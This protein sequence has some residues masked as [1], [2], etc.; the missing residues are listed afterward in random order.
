MSEA[1]ISASQ[2]RWYGSPGHFICGMHCRFH[3]CTKVG[4]FLVSTV[5]EYTP[6][7]MVA[8]GD[9]REG[10]WIAENYPGLDI[11]YQRKYETMVF[12]ITDKKCGDPA[13]GCGMPL[14]NGRMMI[15]ASLLF[16][17]PVAMPSFNNH[18]SYRFMDTEYVHGRGKW[19][20][21]FKEQWSTCEERRA[22]RR[23]R[24]QA[25]KEGRL[26]SKRKGR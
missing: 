17:G 12:E 25:V 15:V 2:W 26:Q 16:S 1:D 9:N 10:D 18:S 20:E 14:H 24:R 8:G 23:R 7:Y 6:P 13:C 21:T 22:L 19:R 3:L 4:R 5:G 11:G